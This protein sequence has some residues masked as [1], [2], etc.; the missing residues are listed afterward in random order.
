MDN[1]FNKYLKSKLSL[2]KM[3][4]QFLNCYI[5][6]EKANELN[7]KENNDYFIYDNFVEVCFHNYSSE[8][9]LAWKYLNI[10]NNFISHEEICDLIEKL[11]QEEF[12]NNIDYYEIY[13]KICVLLIDMVELFYKRKISVKDANKY[14]IKYDDFYD[15]YNGEVEV[16]DHL[17][18]GAGESVWCL[19]DIDNNMI[20]RNIFDEKRKYFVDELLNKN[21]NIEK[22]LKKI[23]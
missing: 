14:N 9:I 22:S 19:L 11:Y 23:K 12:I 20:G 1:Y 7:I 18:E 16:C 5:T 6:I 10:K 3:V 8:G 15:E 13:L 2:Y 21:N 4:N 17:F